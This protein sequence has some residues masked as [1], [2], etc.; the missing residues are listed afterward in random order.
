M[1][2]NKLLA[3]S[4]CAWVW[5]WRWHEKLCCMQ[6]SDDWGREQ[7]DSPYTPPYY[8]SYCLYCAR[9]LCKWSISGIV[10]LNFE[11]IRLVLLFDWKKS[12][13]STLRLLKYPWNFCSHGRF[14]ATTKGL[15]RL[16]RLE[17]K[18]LLPLGHDADWQLACY[19]ASHGQFS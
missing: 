18:M 15:S 1:P 11:L 6:T 13:K 4:F 12:V 10:F 17:T 2:T 9:R 19:L 14:V 3:I 16:Y 8:G 7:Y 5:G